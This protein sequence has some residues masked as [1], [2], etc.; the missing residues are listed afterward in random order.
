MMKP[1]TW[2]NCWRL[3][4]RAESP[5]SLMALGCAG[6]PRLSAGGESG[7]YRP[8]I[9]VWSDLLQHGPQVNALFLGQPEQRSEIDCGP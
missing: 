6:P 7:R 2:A 5:G 1:S 3:P 8:P 4:D 9:P